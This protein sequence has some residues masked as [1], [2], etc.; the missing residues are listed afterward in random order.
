MT[1]VRSTAAATAMEPDQTVNIEAYALGC[2]RS[3]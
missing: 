3:R 2:S 1:E